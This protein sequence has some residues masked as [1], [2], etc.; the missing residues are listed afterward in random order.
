MADAGCAQNGRRRSGALRERVLAGL[1][2]TPQHAML[3]AKDP[4]WT[5]ECESH[6]RSL[7]QQV[8]YRI[9]DGVGQWL[10]LETSDADN[11]D[12]LAFF[13]QNGFG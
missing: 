1:L 13:R 5:P 2:E 8:D 7:S 10:V 11:A 4:Q 6:V 3:S 12:A 9:L